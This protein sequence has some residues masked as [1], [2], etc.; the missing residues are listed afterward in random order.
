MTIYR[1]QLV[2]LDMDVKKEYGRA[3]KL[4]GEFFISR[5]CRDKVEKE[6]DTSNESI[7][8]LGGSG[9]S[10]GSLHLLVTKDSFFENSSDEDGSI[11]L[12]QIKK[13]QKKWC[14]SRIGRRWQF[15]EARIA[16]QAFQNQ[17]LHVVIHRTMVPIT[18]VACNYA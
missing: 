2:K 12:F 4:D 5:N 8:D 10:Q 6:Y 15:I 18:N 11:K 1:I 14:F 7:G 9:D 3:E 17:I 13:L 16:M